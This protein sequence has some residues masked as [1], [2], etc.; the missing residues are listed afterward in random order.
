MRGTSVA[1]ALR[2]LAV[3][4]GCAL[5]ACAI[6][7]VTGKRELMLV[8]EEREIELGRSYAPQIDAQMGVLRNSSLQ[9]YVSEI[10]MR[11]ARRSERPNLP[12]SFQVMDDP[13]INAFAVPGGY[14]YVTRGILAHMNTEAQLAGVLGHEIGHVTARHS[15]QQMSRQML[16]GLAIALPVAVAPELAGLAQVAGAGLGVLFLKYGRDDELQSDS[17]GLRYMTQDGYDPTGMVDVMRMLDSATRS[18]GGQGPPEWLSTHPSPGNR[19]ALLIDEIQRLGIQPGGREERDSFLR[20]LDGL[21]YGDDPRQGF[22]TNTRF[23]HPEMR[24]ELTFPSGWQTQNSRQAVLGASPNQDAIIQLSLAREA[25]PEA[26]ARSFFSQQGILSDG[27]RSTRVNGLSAAA[28]LFTASTQSGPLTGYV[29][30]VALGG[31]VFQVLGAAPD[32]AWQT[33]AT[34]IRRSLESFRELTDRRALNVEPWRLR[35]VRLS[36][37]TTT[38]ALLRSYRSPIDEQKLAILNQVGVG[39]RIPAGTRV[40]YVE[41]SPRP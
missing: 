35:T 40:K 24:F 20:R 21:V 26:A 33:Y 17:L 7:P 12:W 23:Q 38:G 2:G 3:A 9:A 6:N 8:S 25:S 41:G 15:A 10:G 29:V 34:A 13:L 16:A 39:E 14:I 5:L 1:R 36:S 27:A 37:A 32:S 22:F 4:V 19:E 31:N 11:M 30:F 28:G 18:E